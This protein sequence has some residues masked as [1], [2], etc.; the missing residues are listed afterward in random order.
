MATL[1]FAIEELPDE[2]EVERLPRLA[3]AAFAWTTN[4]DLFD[5][6]RKRNRHAPPPGA[7]AYRGST[8]DSWDFQ[9]VR[10]NGPK[11]LTCTECGE[12]TN[13]PYCVRCGRPTRDGGII[14][15][16]TRMVPTLSYLQD[17]EFVLK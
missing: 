11:E 9:R 8:A 17:D 1:P 10:V 5:G 2:P 3:D 12:T 16:R 6:R 14:A 7:P 13:E 15:T 4:N